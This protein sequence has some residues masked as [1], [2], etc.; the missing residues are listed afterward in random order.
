MKKSSHIY[1]ITLQRDSVSMGDD[2]NAPHQVEIQIGLEITLKE[3]LEQ[4]ISRKY[5]AGVVTGEAM[6]SLENSSG[7]VIAIYAQQWRKIEYLSD[8]NVSVDDIVAQRHVDYGYHLFFRYHQQ[9]DPQLFLQKQKML[10]EK[11]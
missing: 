1:N 6:W 2:I 4:L 9:I 3:G 11:N 8:I 7:K 5:L 10:I